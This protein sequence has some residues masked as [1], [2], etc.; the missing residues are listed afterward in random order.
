MRALFTPWQQATLLLLLH[1]LHKATSGPVKPMVT[2][3]L[4]DYE[5]YFGGRGL[6]QPAQ[7]LCSSTVV[8]TQWHSDAYILS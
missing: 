8:S 6:P 5:S 4:E 1:G 7:A 3:F 2:M